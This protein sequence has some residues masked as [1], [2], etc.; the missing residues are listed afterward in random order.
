MCYIVFTMSTQS[1]GANA[2]QR[3]GSF[4]IAAAVFD[5]LD[6]RAD[7]LAIP[8]NQLIE[9]YLAEGLRR[10]RHPSIAFRDGASGRRPAIVGTRLDVA[11]VITTLRAERGDVTA[12]ANYFKCSQAAVSAALS[13]Y[14]EFTDE[15]DACTDRQARYAAEA[16]ELWRRER[17][18]LTD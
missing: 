1:A 6:E 7:E 10:D 14:A 8:R 5:G 2:K 12:T 18:V 11:Q 13:Y 16:E 4:R 3:H 17:D 9:R 15:V